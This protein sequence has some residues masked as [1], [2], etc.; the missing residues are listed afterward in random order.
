MRKHRL[1]FFDPSKYRAY[2]EFVQSI[3]F[4]DNL[5]FFK[6][7]PEYRLMLENATELMGG[8]YLELIYSKFQLIESEIRAFCELNDRI[9]STKL[10]EIGNLKV[11]PSSLG[12]IFQALRIL[13]HCKQLGLQDIS[14]VEIGAGYGGLL[15]AV[16]QFHRR[17]DVQIQAYRLVDLE[18]PSALQ[19]KYLSHFY[20]D[21]PITFHKASCYGKEIEG[22]NFVISV[23]CFSEILPEH[24]K[25]YTQHLLPKC[26]HGFMIWNTLVRRRQSV[27]EIHQF[28]PHIETFRSVVESPLTGRRNK[29]IYF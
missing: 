8:Q 12:Y 28:F 10:S 9:G 15:L 6:S 21:F 16:N 18:W 19:K 22:D 25:L 14:I 24:Q 13:E 5:S 29:Y 4:I 23:H 11:S 3:L 2:E 20:L 7:N 17:F 26:S 27:V 1:D